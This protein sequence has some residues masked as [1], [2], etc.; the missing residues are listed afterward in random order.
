DLP[1]S[2]TERRGSGSRAGT[3]SASTTWLTLLGGPEGRLGAGTEEAM[4]WEGQRESDEIEDRRGL[5]IPRGGAVIGG[6]G[7]VL[8]LLFS[9]LTGADPRQVLEIAQGVSDVASGPESQQQQGK[10]GAPSDETGRF[11]AVVLGS[12]EDVW[13]EVFSERGRRYER[14]K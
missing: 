13:G 10:E 11:A 14:P 5:R 2:S 6:G 9:M 4:R 7:L 3:R 12:T 8:V 1:S